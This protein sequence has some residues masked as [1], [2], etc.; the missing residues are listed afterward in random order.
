MHYFFKFLIFERERER[1]RE[2]AGERGRDRENPKQTPCSAQS[3]MWGSI[4]Q[5][6]DHDLNQNQESDAQLTEPPRR[7][8]MHYFHVNVF[9][10]SKKIKHYRKFE[11]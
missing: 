7:P 5:P 2:R 1:E 6:W 11:K 8:Q 3:L 9:L 4:L 10:V